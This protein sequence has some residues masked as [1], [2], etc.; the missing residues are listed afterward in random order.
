MNFVYG[1]AVMSHK[2]QQEHIMSSTADRQ[3]FMEEDGES[4]WRHFHDNT[5]A[6]CYKNTRNIFLCFHIQ[7]KSYFG[8]LWCATTK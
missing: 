3:T 8:C 1:G 6:N 4:C 2:S 5:Q 7:K